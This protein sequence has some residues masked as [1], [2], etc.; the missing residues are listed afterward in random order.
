MGKDSMAT[1]RLVYAYLTLLTG[2]KAGTNF[3]LD[4]GTETLL[5]RGSHCHISLE[6]ALCSRVHARLVAS[7]EGWEICDAQSRNGTFVNGQKIDE[8]ILGVGHVVKI[9]GSEFELCFSNEPPTKESEEGPNLQQTLVQEISVGAQTSSEDSFAG[10]PDSQQVKELML[11]Y[12][13]CIKLLGCREPNDVVTGSLEL[14][15]KRTGASIAGFLWVSDDGSLKPKFVLP[16]GAAGRVTLNPSLTELVSEQG[17]AVWVA[18]QSAEGSNLEHFADA[19]CAPLVRRIGGGQRKTLGAIHVYLE[20]GRFRQ[21]DF[22]FIITVANLVTIALANTRELTSLQTDYRRLLRSSAATDEMLG[23]SKPMQTLKAKIQRVSRATGCVL[24]RGESGAGKELVARAIH[25]L[26][27]RA[28]RPMV[29]VNCAAIPADL[30]ESHLFGHK[31]GAFTGAERDHAGYFQQADLGTLFLDEVG[32]LTLE[33]QAKLL[34]ILEGHPFL[35]VGA[36]AEVSVDVRV[37][38][39]TN[40]DLQVYV[41]EGNFREDLFYRLSVFELHLPPLRDREEDVGLMVDHFLDHFRQ[42]HGRPMLGLSEA[43][44]QKLLKYSW[45]GNVR[46]LRNVMDSTVVMAEGEVI[47]PSDLALRDTGS[48]S[49]DTLAIDHWEKKLIVEALHRSGGNVP[50]AAKL[51]SIGRAT[52][53][54]KIEQYK[55]ER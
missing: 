41:R 11:L 7:G 51:L 33:G 31:A 15:K 35:P 23:E 2:E 29:S 10:L 55:I 30:M 40:R 27:P 45:P 50:A 52:L 26:S 16:E 19:I 42:E 22:D 48:D 4:P 6:D 53:Y 18:N 17:H 12:Q 37:I 5:G 43:A 24:V 44:R 47:E 21:S 25:R 28:D 9:G 3:A 1:D 34:R 13:L 8:A 49:L 36:T 20:D 54:R 32:E 14:L 46:Q 38:A 39:A